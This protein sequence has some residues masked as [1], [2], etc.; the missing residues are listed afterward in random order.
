[1]IDGQGVGIGATLIK[2]LKAEFCESVE[3]IASLSQELAKIVG[4]SKEPLPPL[5]REMVK[6]IKEVMKDE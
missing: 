3:L 5:V 4:A 6:N 1:V 2:Y